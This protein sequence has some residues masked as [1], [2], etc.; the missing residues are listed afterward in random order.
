[1][2]ENELQ[3]LEKISEDIKHTQK[4]IVKHSVNFEDTLIDVQRKVFNDQSLTIREQVEGAG[5]AW[6]LFLGFMILMLPIFS[7]LEKL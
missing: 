5:G 3:S 1:M 6:Q 2:F 7:V 4:N